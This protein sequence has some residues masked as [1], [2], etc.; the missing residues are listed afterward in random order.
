MPYSVYPSTR[1]SDNRQLWNTK[2]WKIQPVTVPTT[3]AAL[4]LF[5]FVVALPR[6]NTP[7]EG[8]DSWNATSRRDTADAT[9][10]SKPSIPSD[11]IAYRRA[12][13]ENWTCERIHRAVYH[14]VITIAHRVGARWC[15]TCAK[16]TIDI[17]YYIFR[18]Y[19]HFAKWSFYRFFPTRLRRAK[20]LR[21][22]SLKCKRVK[23]KK[24][25]IDKW[26]IHSTLFVRYLHTH[27][28]THIY[29]QTIRSC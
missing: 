27:T 1:C 21:T 12:V 3:R 11:A 20:Y 28:H 8:L 18:T 16:T 13:V 17:S 25:R 9:Q 19:Y 14:I 4:F 6:K 10:F 7:L 24:D 2:K 26:I 5:S 15:E 29:W 23:R 22:Y